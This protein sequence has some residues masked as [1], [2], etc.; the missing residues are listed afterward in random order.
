MPFPPKIFV[1]GS[2][3]V[4]SLVCT[5]PEARQKSDCVSYSVQSEVREMAFDAHPIENRNRG[6]EANASRLRSD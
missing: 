5:A 4:N 3:S 6:S 1:V 2:V